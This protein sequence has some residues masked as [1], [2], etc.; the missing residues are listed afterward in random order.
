MFSSTSLMN[1][2]SSFMTDCHP[3]VFYWIEHFVLLFGQ[4]EN[5]LRIIPAMFGVLTIPAIYLTIREI[6]NENIAFIS[7]LL[8][9]FSPF[10]IYYSQ[11]ARMYTMWLLFFLISLYIFFKLIKTPSIKTALI[12]GVI[13]GVTFWIHFYTGL[14][15]F[16]L[17]IYSI[18]KNR[19]ALAVWLRYVGY[20]LIGFIIIITPLVP[21][22][23]TILNGW[24]SEQKWFGYMGVS[25]VPGV[26][27]EFAGGNVIIAMLSVILLITG[28]TIMLKLGKENFTFVAFI[29]TSCLLSAIGLSYKLPMVARYLFPLYVFILIPMAVSI[30]T[31]FDFFEKKKVYTGSLVIILIALIFFPVL[32]EYYS[33]P[34]KEDHRMEAREIS[35]ITNDGDYFI[36]LTNGRVFQH[37]Y[38]NETDK[39]L[40]FTCQT[41]EDLLYLNSIREKSRMIIMPQFDPAGYEKELEWINTHY[42]DIKILEN[43]AKVYI[44]D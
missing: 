15:F 22:L 36:L 20:S 35:I 37:Y 31:L 11:E 2:W 17:L 21:S 38:H 39:V 13:S 40:I 1:I 19:D 3:P 29:I 41:Y 5:F 33:Q 12:F 18:I 43:N 6:F 7:S 25:V 28:G 9:T 27:M 44:I 42:D 34:V 14:F 24:P 30:S 16:L 32:G 4:D 10:H 26:I 23:L 8:I